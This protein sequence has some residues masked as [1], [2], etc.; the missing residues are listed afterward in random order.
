MSGAS[1]RWR[2]WAPLL[3]C[4][5]WL[6]A[7]AWVRPLALPDEGRYAGVAWEMVRTGQWLTPT[8]DGLPYFHKPPLFYWI[9]ASALT[10]FGLHEWPARLA[11]FLGAVLAAA[12][13]FLFARRWFGEKVAPW[14]LAVF[15]TAPLSYFGA[16][17]ANLD[18]LVAG[19]ITATLCCGAHAVLSEPGRER[20][21]GAAGAWLFA[22]LGVLAKGLIG[23]V[24]P[25]LV[26]VGWLALIRRPRGLLT[27]LSW[28]G[29][30]L[31]LAVA[32][33]WFVLMQ[34]RFPGFFHY[35]FVVQHFQR[36]SGTGFNN[37]HA[38][39]FY[40]VVLV[41]LALPWTPW[42]LAWARAG[43][44]RAED[45]LPQRLLLV[46]WA[47][48]ITLFFSLP[49]SKLVGYIFPVAA[50]LAI[51]LADGA[52]QLVEAR[53]RW[54]SWLK[55]T[56]GVAAGLCLVATIAF[57]L[58]ADV[59]Q[60]ELARVLRAG[61]QPGDSI[62]FVGDYYFAVGF[63]ARLQEPVGVVSDWSPAAVQS[64]DNWRKE[65][66]DAAQFLPGQRVLLSPQALDALPCEGRRLWVMG[67]DGAAKT[68][69]W[70]DT[71]A[72]RTQSRGLSLWRVDPAVPGAVNPACAG[73]PS[74]N[75][76]GRS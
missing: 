57:T 70:L 66:G 30:L 23:A 40:P 6:A 54:A 71:A 20:T 7:T 74:A 62:V 75:S 17:Y 58:T 27:L 4:I 28:R 25:F 31:F 16:Q 52:L 41:L 2:A 8:L 67:A 73:T 72:S 45:R 64:R 13:I 38:A 12:S 32:G 44:W 65:L 18:M 36:F 10:V 22:A 48:V 51:L 69:P 34:E 35:F 76:A 19:C 42:A 1:L 9:T 3:A 33:P 26:L 68:H 39:W 47:L 60:R 14:A 21:W 5:A 29:A 43:F 55:A 37:A 53:Q 56:A 63:Y 11:P 49:N 46:A 15:A 59:R 61:L 24:L 50:P